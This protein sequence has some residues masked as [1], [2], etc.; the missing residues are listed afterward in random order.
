MR[1]IVAKLGKSALCADGA[2]STPRGWGASSTLASRCTRR[3]PTYQGLVGMSLDEPTDPFPGK[4]L[5][6]LRT[7]RLAQPRPAASE[8]GEIDDEASE[9]GSSGSSDVS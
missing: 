8:K 2:R 7:R 6:S 5:D 4:T 3:K 1:Q 9:T